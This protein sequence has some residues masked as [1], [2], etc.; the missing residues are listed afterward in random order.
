MTYSCKHSTSSKNPARA[1]I[2]FNGSFYLAMA[3]SIAA[4]LT[5]VYAQSDKESTIRAINKY[6]F[7]Q[8]NGQ[9]AKAVKSIPAEKTPSEDESWENIWTNMQTSF[10]LPCEDFFKKEKPTDGLSG[11]LS[12][13]Y[14]LSDIASRQGSGSS[15]QGVPLSSAVVGASLSYVPIG[16]WFVNLSVM[17]YWYPERKQSWNPDF[18][19]SFGY[20]DWHPYTFSFTY[21]NYGGNRFAPQAGEVV[22]RFWEGTF[23]L[24]WKFPSAKL[25][26]YLCVVHPS[27]GIGHSLNANITPQYRDAASGE[28]RFWK[29]DFTLSTKYTIYENFYF[30]FNINLY[31]IAGQQQ[32]WDPDFTY[33]F[34][35][36]DWHPY[37][38]SV[39][40]NNFAGGRFP[41]NPTTLQSKGFFDAFLDGTISVSWSFV[42]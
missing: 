10:S 17:R 37:S 31:P 4:S 18:T 42:F 38:F 3:L 23:S 41:W 22:S 6:G 14:P 8:L 29:T 27:G 7:L 13:T 19:Y 9:G 16:Y 5:C 25:I 34:G 21:Q 20:N 35:Y 11:S 36:F 28:T 24:G 12:V 40:Y 39:Q 2:Y 1:R 33:G 15:S 30:N 26:E 32:P